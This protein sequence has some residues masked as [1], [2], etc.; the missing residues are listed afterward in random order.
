MASVLSF[1]ISSGSKK[2]EPRC[3]CL[4][5]ARASHS[6]KMRYWGFLLSTACPTCGVITQPYYIQGLFLQPTLGLFPQPTLM[7][8]S[9]TTCMSQYYPRH[10][11]VLDMPIL[12]RNDC[13]NTTSGILALELSERSYIKLVQGLFLCCC[14]LAYLNFISW[15]IL[16]RI[17]ASLVLWHLGFIPL[18]FMLA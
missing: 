2:K 13:T 3:V 18:I 16:K 1:L 10:V 7:H 11:S 14:F 17:A 6:H 9:I 15:F 4:S 8:N 12:R 5:E